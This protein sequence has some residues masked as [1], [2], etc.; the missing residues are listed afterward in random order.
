MLKT[1]TKEHLQ[2][3]RDWAEAGEWNGAS[4]RLTPTKVTVSWGYPAETIKPKP[5]TVHE[6]ADKFANFIHGLPI[7]GNLLAEVE[8][9]AED[10]TDLTAELA[11]LKADRDFYRGQVEAIAEWKEA[12]DQ[13]FAEILESGPSFQDA[14]ELAERREDGWAPCIGAVAELEEIL[15]ACRCCE[16]CPECTCHLPVDG[17]YLEALRPGGEPV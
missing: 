5:K 6:W 3:I 15:G 9:H 7:I 8:A 10:E 11:T 12:Q 14:E 4:Y 17:D 2:K 13:R 16:E 1:M